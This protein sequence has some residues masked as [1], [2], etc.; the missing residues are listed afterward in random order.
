[1]KRETAEGVTL[2]S[3]T[4]AI[5][6]TG[7]AP[8]VL[9]ENTFLDA[10]VSHEIMAFLIVILTITLASVGSIHLTMTETLQRMVPDKEA[11]ERV[12][13]GAAAD[14]RAEIN[15]SAWYLFWAFVVCAASLVV[16]GQWH[17]DYVKSAVHGLAITVVILNLLILRDLY[18]T[19][20]VM[21]ST[22]PPSNNGKP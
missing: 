16:K 5:V 3:L 22:S 14:F 15:S 4:G 21:A 1:M 20:F 10:F 2:L 6:L 8:K 13:K 17:N 9:A 7:F 12:E 19:I 11:R 18:K